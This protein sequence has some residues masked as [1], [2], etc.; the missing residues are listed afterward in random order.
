MLAAI[1]DQ[2]R[3]CIMLLGRDDVFGYVNQAAREHLGWTD[4]APLT[5]AAWLE[6][7]P[8]D[9]QA[10]ITTAIDDARNGRGAAAELS[11]TLEDGFKRWIEVECDPL[12][13]TAAG[14][15]ILLIA[16]D[17]TASV[18]RRLEAERKAA[19]SDEVSRE[20]RHRFKNQLAVISSL[21]RL[22]ARNA[23]GTAE[24]TDRFEQRLGALSRAQDFLAVHRNE[25]MDANSAVAQILGASGAG[26][27]IEVAQLP[28]ARLSDEGVQALALLLGE[29]QTNALKYGALTSTE[30][31][32]ELSGVQEEGHLRLFW[33]EACARPC[34][35]PEKQ[36]GGLKLLERM[37]SVPGGRAQVE[38]R[39]DGV[40]VTF[41]IR[42]AS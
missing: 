21:L 11:Y 37:G 38:W 32:I 19:Q 10:R 27:R 36:G 3:E 6:R 1:L 12:C 33:Q 15:Q 20:M 7:W 9:S 24:L 2:S 29:L 42:L 8:Q 28:D 40:A 35:P 30:G 16:R 41:Y 13:N 25:Q 17:V 4:T 23:L 18:N 22:S 34:L 31:K 39:P 14:D 26:E 5:L